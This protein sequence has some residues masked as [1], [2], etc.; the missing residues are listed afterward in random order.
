MDCLSV[1]A[2]EAFFTT[3]A[4]KITKIWNMNSDF[5]SFVLHCYPKT[6]TNMFVITPKDQAAIFSVWSVDSIS[7]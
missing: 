7:R 1:L 2:E 5:V 4:T 3:K 6:K